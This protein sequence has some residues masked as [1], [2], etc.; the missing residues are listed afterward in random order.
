MN[1]RCIWNWLLLAYVFVSS[2]SG[3]DILRVSMCLLIPKNRMWDYTLKLN[4]D[5]MGLKLLPEIGFQNDISSDIQNSVY[6]G[7]GYATLNIQVYILGL[8]KTGTQV[9]DSTW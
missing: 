6:L 2:L 4:S 3:L 9:L 7:W 8:P 1:Y 5:R